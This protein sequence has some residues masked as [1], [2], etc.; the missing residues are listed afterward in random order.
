MATRD[1]LHSLIEALPEELL[2]EAAARLGELD[3]SLLRALLSGADDA[4]VTLYRPVGQKELDLIA[5][6]DYRRFPPRLPQ[7]P[8]FYPVL[9]QEY[10]T[11]IARD[12][13]TTDAASGYV[14]CVTRF[15]VRSD[16]L[17]RYEVQQVG[18]K[19]HLEYW[20]PAEELPEFNGAIVGQIEVIARFPP[21]EA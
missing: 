8:I 3:N 14:G 2:D 4:T 9:N 10:A 1:D 21:G 11:Q 13:N 18:S 15:R 6:S 12:W 19:V 7:Q 16:F 5:E 20:I 17:R